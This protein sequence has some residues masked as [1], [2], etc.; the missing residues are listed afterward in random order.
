[1]A[2]YKEDGSKVASPVFPYSLRFEPNSD[3]SYDGSNYDKT[4]FEQLGEIQSGTT[5]YSVYAMD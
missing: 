1:M 2:A 3:L 5:I 4:V